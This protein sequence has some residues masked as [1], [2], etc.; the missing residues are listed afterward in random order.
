MEPRTSKQTGGDP[1]RATKTE[2]SEWLDAMESLLAKG[3]PEWDDGLGDDSAPP[4]PNP[5][6]SST[7]SMDAVRALRSALDGVHVVGRWK[8]AVWA[9]SNHTAEIKSVIELP[10][11]L[12]IAA[13]GFELA[14][15]HGCFTT[16]FGIKRIG[17][18][19]ALDAIDESLFVQGEGIVFLLCH[20]Q[21]TSKYEASVRQLKRDVLGDA[22]SA[23]V[24]DAQ[25]MTF[26]VLL[27][28]FHAMECHSEQWHMCVV[29]YF[30]PGNRMEW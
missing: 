8:H 14:P 20:D 13:Y 28:G 30:A 7:A 16:V 23:L 10:R 21:V 12:R 17:E 6:L 27:C 22:D 25:W 3:V 24:P 18:D 2:I 5:M 19:V 1:E 9:G 15:K 11:G 4:F 29:G 26:L